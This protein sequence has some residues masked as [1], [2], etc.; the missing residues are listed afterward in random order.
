[1]TEPFTG[2]IR[3]FAGTFAP[4]SWALCDGQI[5]QIS[6]NEALFSL[7][8]SIYGGNGRTTFGLPDLRG[9]LPIHFGQGPGLSNR[10]LGS[11]GGA[12]R[13][14]LSAAELPSHRHSFTATGAAAS[15]TT[16]AGNT[17][18]TEP[19]M[20]IYGSSP[21]VPLNSATSTNAGGGGDHSNVMPFLAINFI[22]CLFGNHP[23]QI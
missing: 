18:A 23:S 17:T 12:E 9:R 13:V 16:P 4:R 5:L 22:I 7:L 14:N 6:A 11:G 15:D 19:A 2:E 21:S 8:G 10:P 20:N 3:M 1:M